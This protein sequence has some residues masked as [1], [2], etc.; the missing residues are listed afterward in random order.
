MKDIRVLDCTLRDGGYIN[1]WEFGKEKSKFIINYLDKAGINYIEVGFIKE[2]H[3]S[4]TKTLFASFEDINAF[5]PENID[6]NKLFA[7]ITYGQF[8]IEKIP[9]A[10]K[11]IVKGIRLI[12]KKQHTK[13]ALDYCKELKKKGYKLFI[14]PTFIDQFTDID[15]FALFAL[16]LAGNYFNP[17]IF[18]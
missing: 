16:V 11:S 5:L 12:F 4:E 15:N 17:V 18:L 8:P 14:N 6:H 1:N 13:A 2:G 3:P 9:D 7:M 10:D